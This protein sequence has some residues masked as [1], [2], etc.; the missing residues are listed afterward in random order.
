MCDIPNGFRDRAILMCS[1]KIIDKK[2]ILIFIVQVTD[3]LF[4]NKFSKIPPLTSMHFATRV[5]T[6]R[7]ARLSSS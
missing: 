3:M 1:Y 2:V 7:V 6:W 4:Y 5:R